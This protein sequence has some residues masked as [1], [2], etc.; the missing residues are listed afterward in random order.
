MKDITVH[1]KEELKN[2]QYIYNLY[3]PIVQS[4]K[5]RKIWVS[6]VD[7]IGCDMTFVI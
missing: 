7:I 6:R 5:L 3:K 1:L 4:L 2:E